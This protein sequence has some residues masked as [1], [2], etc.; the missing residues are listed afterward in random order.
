[1]VPLNVVPQ[2]WDKQ[3]LVLCS[4]TQMGS[5]WGDSALLGGGGRELVWGWSLGPTKTPSH[6]DAALGLLGTDPEKH[7]RGK[8]RGLNTQ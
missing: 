1:M 3:S 7:K 5:G 2:P 6:E 8:V 4:L